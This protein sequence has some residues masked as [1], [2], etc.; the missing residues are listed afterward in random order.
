MII[1]NISAHAFSS[2][3]PGQEGFLGITEPPP[4]LTLTPAGHLLVAVCLGVI[5]AVGL[6]ANVLVLTLFCRYRSLRTPMNL[7]LVSISVSDL[8]VSAFGTPLS[9]AASVRGRWLYGRAGCVWYGFL[10]ACLG[11]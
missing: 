5:G 1:S 11:E 9:F 8:L 6:L 4:S 10:N 2:A 7:L 3:P